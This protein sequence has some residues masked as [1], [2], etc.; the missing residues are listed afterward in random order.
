M[1]RSAIDHAADELFEA[2]VVRVARAVYAPDRPFQGSTVLDGR[3]R[4]AVIIGD[5]VV[6]VVEATTSRA[7]E[8]AKYDGTK[9]RDA[10]ERL[11]REHRF[12]AVKGFFV[13]QDD[14]TAQQ[15]DAIAALN[16]PVTAC[17]IA[18]FRSQLIDSR[19]YLEMRLR[20][21]F[22]SARNPFNDS[23]TDLERYIPL[24]FS[25]GG[26]DA[27]A[28]TSHS[29]D[30]IVRRMSDGLVT[31][32]L[33]DFG[34]GKSM[35]LREVHSSLAGRHYKDAFRP[36]PMTLNLRDHQ[37]QKD[38]DEAIRRHATKLGFESPSKLVKAWRAGQIHVLLDGFDEIAASGWR[39]RSPDL[40]RIRRDSVELVRRFAEESPQSAGLLISGRRHFFD[41]EDELL[42]SLGMRNRSP[43]ILRTDEFTEE[44]VRT[45]LADRSWS[46][47][48]PD[49]LPSH[50]LL[51]GYLAGA[52]ALQGLAEKDLPDPAPGWDYLIDRICE[53][54]ARIEQG[55]DG[56]TIRKVMER[57]AT[58][59]RGRGTGQ[60]PVL[61]RDLAQAFEQ[62]ATYPPDEG[63]YQVLQRLP[64]LGAQD[65]TDGSR[66]F[67]DAALLD[68]ARAADVVRYATNSDDALE[69]FTN[70]TV[71]LG[72]LGIAVG[73]LQSE[74]MGVTA[75]QLNAAAK[76]LQSRGGA[77]AL[78]FDLVRVGA[79]LGASKPGA[80]N[81][82]DL[83]IESFTLSDSESDFEAVTL[84][85]CVIESLDLTEYDGEWGIPHF[86]RCMFGTVLGAA[87]TSALPA[88]RFT[89]CSFD[90]FDPSSKTTHGI[91]AMP[92][93]KPAQKAL[94]TILK[95][96]YMQAGGGR[97]E[98]AL[99]RGLSPELKGH[100]GRAI[101]QLQSEGWLIE[102]RTA[103]R[104]LYLPVKGLRA[105]VRA[106]LEAPA[107]TSEE[108]VRGFS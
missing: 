71:P 14:P 18:Q 99:V 43:L 91:V 36:F 78:A 70:L 39:G 23:T 81:F 22:G 75:G 94:L 55:L 21:A 83:T 104:T 12:K 90:A 63:S 20:Y 25:S 59:A 17:S 51:L 27:A 34:A 33:G 76:K 65:V 56:G 86:D 32:V 67:I 85:D 77:D 82:A 72:P 19:E 92:G 28:R 101:A 9:L 2:E 58:V 54:E 100:V 1:G 108:V 4:D 97:K 13:T 30:D 53:R 52:D 96:V 60:G 26:R 84:R 37:G 61:T 87:S 103:G 31:I 89:D 73:A 48:L 50:P 46:G 93:L 49:W 95:K 3:E 107:T 42:V 74:R 47:E 57:L 6:V 44:Q 105:R 79:E 41:T 64:G 106:I 45:Y 69:T 11:A 35:S 68:A 8:K 10:C 15:R 7:L 80:L 102:S 24:G 98:S 16:A 66:F 88:G 62:V 40:R 29:V 38:P 5:D